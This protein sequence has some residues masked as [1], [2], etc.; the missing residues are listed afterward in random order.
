MKQ[1]LLV[2]ILF[3]TS[4]SS[5]SAQS[6]EAKID[7]R[8]DIYDGSTDKF[9]F[10]I[11]FVE[12]GN[13]GQAKF[14]TDKTAKGTLVMEH[15]QEN[16]KRSQ[17][18][19]ID[20]LNYKGIS[21]QPFWIANVIWVYADY[22]MVERI[23]K[24]PEVKRI[25][26][27]SRMRII[28][29]IPSNNLNK[30]PE[31]Q[32]GIIQ[33]NVDDVWEMGIKGQG[34]VIGGQ[35]TGYDW[36]HESLQSKYRGWNGDDVK[37]DHNYNWHDAIH[38]Y[39]S[40]H[41]SQN[42]PCGLDVN[43]PCDDGSHGT[44]TMGTMIGE[45]DDLKI[46]VAP[47]ATWIGCRNME[48]GWGTPQ[49]YLECFQWFLAPTDLNGENADPSKAPHVINNS[50]GCPDVEGCNPNNFNLL[51]DAINNLKTAGVVVVVSAGNSGPN[52]ETINTPAAIFENSFTIGALGENEVI[53]GF[54]SRGLVTVDGS[55]RMKPNVTAPGV[56]VKSAVPGNGYSSY[57]G[58][59]MAG[60]HVAGLV[61]LLIS[62]DPT[63]AGDVERIETI[64]EQTAIS[65]TSSQD[66]GTALGTSIPNAVYGFGTVDALSAVTAVLES[67]I[68]PEETPALSI[69]PNPTTGIFYIQYI[70]FNELANL[71]LFASDGKR[72]FNGTINFEG[73]NKI[74]EIDISKLVNGIYFYR[75]CSDEDCKEGR[76]IKMGQ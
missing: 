57:S 33:M 61:A 38:D 76:I 59:S 52:C 35:D 9:E 71:E 4:I 47:E 36:E 41:Q 21:Y 49:T 15:L 60:P 29:P 17:V 63:L 40:K 28:E 6:W 72:V 16:A 7:N 53:A 3:I 5:I 14:L 20:I 44:H 62:A 30:N 27:N 22:E 70:G 24:L 39:D 37:T 75:L 23:A 73:G 32:W 8:L 51:E 69:Y 45:T 67:Q 42:N 54:S 50:W 18:A 19:V 12:K 2:L 34:V 10:L 13:V 11:Q 65:R 26:E 66:C 68:T 56:N 43:Y 25:S 55:N 1:L 74:R 46:G 58:T 31:V 48:R 64:I